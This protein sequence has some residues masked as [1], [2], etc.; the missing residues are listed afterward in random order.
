MSM[1]SLTKNRTAY[2]G[3]LAAFCLILSYVESLLPI[4][5]PVPGIKIGLS[6]LPVVICLGVFG[7]FYGILLSVVKAV[8]C[9]LLFGNFNVLMYSLTGAL[10]SSVIMSLCFGCKRIHIPVVSSIGGVFHNLGQFIV[11]YIIL[12]SD[13]LF[14]YLPLLIISGLFTGLILGFVANMTI[15]PIKKLIYKGALL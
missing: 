2:L 9:S 7:P 5:M 14:Y 12:K 1:Q 4:P 11:A 10:L 8:L 15:K 3:V 6:N 13:G